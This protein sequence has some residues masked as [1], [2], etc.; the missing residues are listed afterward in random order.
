MLCH[1]NEDKTLEKAEAALD[2][3]LRT[4][5]PAKNEREEFLDKI[6]GELAAKYFVAHR[7]ADL[8]M[9]LLMEHCHG[10]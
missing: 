4:I 9:K 5:I 6:T 3:I 2:A 7:G 8:I 10:N 1:V